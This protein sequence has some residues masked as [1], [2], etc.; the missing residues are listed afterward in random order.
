[1]PE[2]NPR[3]RTAAIIKNR[4]IAL[5][6]GLMDLDEIW[7]GDASRPF[8]PTQPPSSKIK[9]I[10]IKNRLTDFDKIWHSDAT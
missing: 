8:G 6:N 3:W 10:D 9:K 7:H 2:T 5:C 4:K 1:M